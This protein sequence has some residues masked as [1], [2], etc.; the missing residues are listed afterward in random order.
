MAV[1]HTDPATKPSKAQ[2]KAT[3]KKSAAGSAL[4]ADLGLSSD[5]LLEMYR[6]VALSGRST[7][8]CGS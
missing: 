3:P 1:T 6:L 7:S 8:G 5:D 2:P 4:G